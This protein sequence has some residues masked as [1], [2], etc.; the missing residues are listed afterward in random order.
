MDYK[1]FIKKMN[2]MVIKENR[3]AVKL[4]SKEKRAERREHRFQSAKV[5]ERNIH[6]TRRVRE[7]REVLDR[8]KL[9][10]MTTEDDR[11]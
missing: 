8:N 2:A 1:D 3:G 5:K 11:D 9:M 10:S 6:Q 7:M 4:S